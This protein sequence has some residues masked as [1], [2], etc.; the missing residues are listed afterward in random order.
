MSPDPSDEGGGH[1]KSPKP[2]DPRQDAQHCT[3]TSRTFR[4]TILTEMMADEF[5]FLRPEIIT[6]SG[7]TPTPWSGPF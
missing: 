7:S 3:Q 2:R 1:G 6:V 5:N 4:S